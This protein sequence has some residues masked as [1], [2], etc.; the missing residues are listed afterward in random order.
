MGLGASVQQT[1]GVV[2][3]EK[4]LQKR[5]RRGGGQIIHHRL[6]ASVVPDLMRYT[7]RGEILVVVNRCGG[8]KSVRLRSLLTSQLA[9]WLA[10]LASA[11]A[12]A[13][14]QAAAAARA[15]LESERDA[16]RDAELALATA[17][18]EVA[19]KAEG[20]ARLEASARALTQ[21]ADEQAAQLQQLSV[22][23]L[24][25]QA[26]TLTRTLTLTLILTLNLTLTLTL[27]LILTL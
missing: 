5:S 27:T 20:I 21:R 17:R 2:D 3:R 22:A 26:L 15:E 16:R 9:P 19:T 10:Q 7:R 23:R 18:G 25:A 6:A 14:E 8:W 4:F 13:R 24:E 11:Q 1:A 12:A